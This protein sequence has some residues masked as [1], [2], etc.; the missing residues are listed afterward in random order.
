M[1][2]VLL[3]LG[4]SFLSHVWEWFQRKHFTKFMI[5]KLGFEKHNRARQLQA[6]CSAW[7][8]ISLERREQMLINSACML[9]SWIDSYFVTGPEMGPVGNSKRSMKLLLFTRNLQTSNTGSQG[10]NVYSLGRS[11]CQR[12]CTV[13]WK[14]EVQRLESGRWTSF[15]RSRKVSYR[16]DFRG[17]MNSQIPF[18]LAHGVKS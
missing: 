6:C 2:L 15:Y 11:Q 12:N 8:G 17:K 10:A 16:C 3:L 18:T 5:F 14:L 4:V 1:R 9:S 7:E 13:H